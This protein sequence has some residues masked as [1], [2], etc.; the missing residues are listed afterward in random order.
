MHNR[1]R[2]LGRIRYTSI[3]Q[4]NQLMEPQG[5]LMLAAAVFAVLALGLFALVWFWP[6]LFDDTPP[7]MEPAPLTE[8]QREQIREDLRETLRVQAE[9]GP[10]MPVEEQEAIREALTEQA[11]A[12]ESN[13]NEDEKDDIRAQLRAQMEQ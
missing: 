4:G 1:R 5:R 10:S 12:S 11:A 9:T 2:A 6:V 7:V 3:M 8:E 13:L